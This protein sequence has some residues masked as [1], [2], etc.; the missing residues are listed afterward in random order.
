[1]TTQLD[2]F[3]SGSAAVRQLGDLSLVNGLMYVPRYISATEASLLW[4][5]VD[6]N[7]WLRD[8]KRRVQHYGYKYDYKARRVDYSMRLGELPSWGRVLASKLT[9]DGYFSQLPDQII[10]NEYKPGQ[11]ISDHIDCEPCFEDTVISL[12]LGSSCV[13]NLTN[14]RTGQRIPLF[15]EPCSIV[16]LK[17]QSRYDWMHGIPPRKT[18]VFQN[19]RYPRTRRISLTFRKVILQDES[20]CP[21]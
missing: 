2:I 16:V 1:M 18:D 17:G 13:M 5:H 19:R 7:P 4:E 11:G 15:L 12:S 21:T 3:N 14:K 20:F 9:N 6:Q 10:V 8:L